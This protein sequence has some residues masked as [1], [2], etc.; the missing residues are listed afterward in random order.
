MGELILDYEKL[1]RLISID[2]RPKWLSPAQAAIYTGLPMRTLEQYR[3][4]KK[5]P[6]FS[7]VGKHVRYNSRDVDNWLRSLQDE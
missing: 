5:G 7:R 1:A 6:K 2:L 4:E 3:T